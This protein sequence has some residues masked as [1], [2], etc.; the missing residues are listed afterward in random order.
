MMEHLGTYIEQLGTPSSLADAIRERD[1][2]IESACQFSLN[3]D[4]YRGLLDEI[5]AAIG[6]EAWKADNGDVVDDEPVRARLPD[7]VRKLLA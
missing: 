3:E 7:L 6:P 1:M 2:W 4:Y 5:A